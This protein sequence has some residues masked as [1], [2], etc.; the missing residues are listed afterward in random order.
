MRVAVTG[1]TSDFGTAILPVLYDD[2]EIVEVVGTGRTRQPRAIHPK[3]R[4]ERHDVRSPD[5]RGAFAGCD[6]VVHLAFAV[7]E[8][9]DKAEAH[10]VNLGGTENVIRCAYAA[11]VRQLVIASSVSAYGVHDW[12][13]FVD[14]DVFPRGNHDRYYF[15]DKAEVE[16]FVQWW[17]PRHPEMRICLLR[18]PF[19]VGPS[20]ANTALTMLA[21]PVLPYPDP[22]AGA[23]QMLHERDLA[24][25]F[26]RAVKLPIEGAYN[27]APP[28]RLRP[29]E[30]AEIHGQRLIPV[31]QAPA[32]RVTDLLFA[33]RLMPGSGD[34]VLPGEAT[35]DSASFRHET[36]WTPTFNSRE[37]AH[38]MLLQH[39][40]PVVGTRGELRRHEVAEAALETSTRIASQQCDL[41][42]ELRELTGGS[43]CFETA[44]KD[45]EHAFLDVAGHSIHLEVHR[46]AGPARGTSLI[47]AG[48]GTHA[49][50][51]SPIAVALARQGNDVVLVDLPGHG[52]STGRRGDA[53]ADRARRAVHAARRFAAE[54]LAAPVASFGAGTASPH[55][56]TRALSLLA[57]I[58]PLAPLPVPAALRFGDPLAC[59]SITARTGLAHAPEDPFA[60][61]RFIAAETAPV[62]E[63]QP[64]PVAGTGELLV[65]GAWS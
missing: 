53:P 32:R 38:I 26:H 65:A 6:A 41:M 64:E 18:P 31:P 58:A 51:Y 16:H 25:A 11:G 23:I 13:D 48:P 1:C 29:R 59:R 44:L 60:L 8:M 61:A 63:P 19:V 14:E 35:V 10:D 46:A 33:L 22:D 40:R 54:R 3:L 21:Q 37:L 4:F 17:A 36:G 62:A 15:Y 9:H 52:L 39:G 57:R 49:R 5:L 43:E 45:V 50:L 42:P 24:S 47:K 12:P 20:F 30:I 28:D 55:R 34:W 27:I 56:P 2:P 7:E